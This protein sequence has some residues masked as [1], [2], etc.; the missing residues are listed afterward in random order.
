MISWW[1][2][3]AVCTL[4]K[5]MIVAAFDEDVEKFLEIANKIKGSQVPISNLSALCDQEKVKKM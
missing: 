1:Q 2:L 3:T 5:N 4:S